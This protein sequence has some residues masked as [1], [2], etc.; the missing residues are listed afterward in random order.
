[1]NSDQF[2]L[3]ANSSSDSLHSDWTQT[4]PESP[5]QFWFVSTVSSGS[6]QNNPQFAVTCE[7]ILSLHAD[8]FI[9]LSLSLL[10]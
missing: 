8:D 7:G 9:R 3:L 1:M 2:H 4:E 5:E 10:S 6:V